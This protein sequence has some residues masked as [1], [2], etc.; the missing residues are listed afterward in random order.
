VISL[1][2]AEATYSIGFTSPVK[3]PLRVCLLLGI[4]VSEIVWMARGLIIE[5]DLGES[6][7]RLV[8]VDDSF[9]KKNVCYLLEAFREV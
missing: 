9:V 7:R 5:F 1:K 3:I 8:D 4:A 6:I 2:A